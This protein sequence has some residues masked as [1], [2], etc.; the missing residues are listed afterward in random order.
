MG[1]LTRGIGLAIGT[2]ALVGMTLAGC[3]KDEGKDN[4]EKPTEPAKSSSMPSPSA[5]SPAPQPG[6]QPPSP[7]EKAPT[8]TP[9]GPNSFTP[10]VL[11]PPA[12]TALP[13][14]VVTGQ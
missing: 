12:P 7:T 10:S 11:A 8:L 5:S 14:N 6:G 3:G 1:N 9:G 4:K 13:G 2:T